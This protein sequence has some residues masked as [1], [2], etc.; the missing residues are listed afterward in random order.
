MCVCVCIYIYIYIYIYI[1]AHIHQIL[2]CQIN[3]LNYVNCKVIEK[4]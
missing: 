2:F 3:A 1:N 4:Y